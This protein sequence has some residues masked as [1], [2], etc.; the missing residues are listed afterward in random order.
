MAVGKITGVAVG[1]F[2]PPLPP[3][4]AVAVG[5]SD[6]DGVAVEV[7]VEVELDEL[8]FEDV[9]DK[10]LS[11]SAACCESVILA[12]SAALAPPMR[13]V[14]INASAT[15]LLRKWNGPLPIR[16][17]LRTWPSALVCK[18]HSRCD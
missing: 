9:W 8:L 5:E 7:K 17:S 6:F 3:E 18:A 4:A 12:A 16:C 2:W 11:A 13:Q 1:E 14:P 10:L 15:L